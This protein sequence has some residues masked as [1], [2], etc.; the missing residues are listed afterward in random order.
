MFKK[1]WYK[2]FTYEFI[3]LKDGEWRTRLSGKVIAKNTDDALKKIR[4]MVKNRE[5]D[6][7]LIEQ[8]GE[9]VYR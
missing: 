4:K 7:L 2:D 8:T 1:R 9:A 5:F 3:K 6:R